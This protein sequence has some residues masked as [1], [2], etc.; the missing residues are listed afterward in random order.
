[1]ALLPW[2]KSPGMSAWSVSV[3]A[4]VCYDTLNGSGGFLAQVDDQL[5]D[6]AA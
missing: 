2:I 4:T 6:D 5:F 1:M 3:L